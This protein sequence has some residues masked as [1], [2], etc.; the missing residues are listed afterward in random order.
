MNKI[1]PS[2]THA[3]LTEKTESSTPKSIRDFFL[4]KLVLAFN[5]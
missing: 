2:L 4:L 3:D 5:L 1:E